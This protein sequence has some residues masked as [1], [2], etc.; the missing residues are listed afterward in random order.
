MYRPNVKEKSLYLGCLCSYFTH[1]VR[2]T[3]DPE[4]DFLWVEMMANDS[5]SFWE[6]VK[7]A[8]NFIF[9]RWEYSGSVASC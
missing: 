3:T 8:W 9:K 1:T 5:D 2:Y 6:R 7:K 4:E